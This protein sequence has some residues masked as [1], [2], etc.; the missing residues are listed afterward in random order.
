[1]TAAKADEISMN[2][3]A[4]I[5]RLETQQLQALLVDDPPSIEGKGKGKSNKGKT[6][7][8]TWVTELQQ[9]GQRTPEHLEGVPGLPPEDLQKVQ[10]S[11]E[12]AGFSIDIKSFLEIPEDKA[13]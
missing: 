12:L 1:L 10:E 11:R 13:D 8:P 9:D 7:R 3:T 2:R 5:P 4:K 6:N